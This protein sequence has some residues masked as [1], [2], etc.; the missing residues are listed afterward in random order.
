[1]AV[2][3]GTQFVQLALRFVGT[4]YRYGGS[5]P[6]GFDCSGLV[7]Y[8]LGR[9]GI[10][11]PRTS[12]QQ[13]AWTRRVDYRF[14]KP[15]DLVFLNFPG[16]SSP[17]HVMIWL[18]GN[19]VLQAPS[20]GQLVKVSKFDPQKPGTNEWGATV[21][22]Y[23]RIPGLSYAG[24]S[25]STAG[26]SSAGSI[27]AGAVG[28]I[29]NPVGTAAGAVGGIGSTAEATGHLFGKLLDPHFWLRALE[30][31]GGFLI[32]ML[33][34]YLL[35]RQAGLSDVPQP[36]TPGLSDEALAEL[37][38]SPGRAAHRGPRRRPA[39]RHEVGEAAERR[40]AIR[41]RSESAQPSDEIPF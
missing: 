27:A 9:M 26:G 8:V 23:G 1:M 10:S 4:P 31:V 28:A 24:E 35:T 3:T 30:V 15:G 13:Y 41:R 29:T 20:T 36:P 22:G 11:A 21:V 19:R 39:R 5:R 14:L 6:S 7:Q 25:T 12:E 17:G 33:G 2:R 16:E 34:L 32:L 40:A 38:F 18:G 37:Q